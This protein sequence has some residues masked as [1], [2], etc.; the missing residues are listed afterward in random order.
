VQPSVKSAQLVGVFDRIA[1]RWYNDAL[2]HVESRQVL[3]K[4]V[5]GF[6]CNVC[7]FAPGPDFAT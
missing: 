6:C 3:G 2:N 4:I 5:V 7:R 1:Q